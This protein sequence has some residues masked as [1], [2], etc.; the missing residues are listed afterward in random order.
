MLLGWSQADLGKA[1]DL[2]EVTVP[3]LEARDGDL[4]SRPETG[5]KIMTPQARRGSKIDWTSAAKDAL[6]WVRPVDMATR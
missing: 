3:R 6:L 1:A 5:K 2:G 4:V